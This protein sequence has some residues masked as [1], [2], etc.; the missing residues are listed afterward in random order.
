MIGGLLGGLSIAGSLE[1]FNYSDF[2]SGFSVWAFQ[3]RFDTLIML[4]ILPLTVGLFMVSRKGI[5]EADSIL[6]LIF[7]IL[8]LAPL[9]SGLTSFNVQQYRFMPLVVFFAMGVG[10]LLS[11]KITQPAS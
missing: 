4:F 10:I 7:G 2:W 8:L 9:L 5:P 1:G 3:L 6:V 11:K